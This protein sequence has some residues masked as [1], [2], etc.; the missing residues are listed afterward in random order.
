MV[1]NGIVL[2]SH[3]QCAMEN[4]RFLMVNHIIF[5]GC[6]T[7]I[8]IVV[9]VFFTWNDLPS[10][11]WDVEFFK[12]MERYL[13]VKKCFIILYNQSWL[14]VVMDLS[15]GKLSSIA[16][17]KTTIFQYFSWVPSGNLT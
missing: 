3:I 8:A 17:W 1:I 9:E 16:N 13:M 10:T 14:I 6:T 7:Y 4:H 15:S 2:W 5:S 11:W 12:W